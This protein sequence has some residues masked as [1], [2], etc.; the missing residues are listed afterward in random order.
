MSHPVPGPG[1]G[2][3][4]EPDLDLAEQFFVQHGLPYFVDPIRADVHARL[5]RRRLFGVV[6]A[7]LLVGVALGTDQ[8]AATRA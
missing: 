4:R 6:A 8:R 2:R 7:A 3:E 5:T 1:T